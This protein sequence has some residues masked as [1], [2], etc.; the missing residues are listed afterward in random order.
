M[1]GLQLKIK[2][3][4]KMR[5][6]LIISALML[7]M[8]MASA[9]VF[10]FNSS[11]KRY[12]QNG[13]FGKKIDVFLD[14]NVRTTDT[15]V[16]NLKN[17]TYRPDTLL[18]VRCNV[19]MK[20]ES[21]SK[22]IIEVPSD[23]R[24]GDDNIF[25][26]EGNPGRYISVTVCN[27]SANVTRLKNVGSGRHL[28][29]FKYAKSVSFH[30]VNTT[31]NKSKCTNLDMR[32]CSNIDVHDCLFTNYNDEAIEG[33]CLWIEGTT[34]NVNIYN[35]TFRK[36]GNDEVIAVFNRNT[37]IDEK[38]LIEKRGIKIYG[39]KFYYG[40]ANEIERT[41][42]M[43]IS[44][45][46]SDDYIQYLGQKTAVH[47]KISDFEV[48]D[49][50]FYINDLVRRC[51]WLGFRNHTEVNRFKIT[52]NRFNYGEFAFAGKEYANDICITDSTLNKNEFEVSNNIFKSNDKICINGMHSCLMVNDA[53]VNFSGNQLIAKYGLT[54]LLV[55]HAGG[56][57]TMNSNV[58]SNLCYLG[59]VSQWNGVEYLKL[60]ATSNSF[61][62]NT[63]IYCNKLKKA[64][65]DF[66][67]NTFNSDKVEFFLQ[68]SAANGNLIFKDNIVNV[69]A[70]AGYGKLYVSYDEKP[71]YSFGNVQVEN[72]TFN[73][74]QSDL[75]NSF[76]AGTRAVVSGNKYEGAID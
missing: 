76:P 32:Q 23:L 56:A 35:N 14:K 64:D 17:G 3:T 38:P 44:C 6:I 66:R 31:L 68:N 27:L 43:L 21:I 34:H 7:T 57:V 61:S 51:F 50:D 30:G 48:S 29:K 20:G 54:L 15:V 59:S 33:G 42:D 74:K 16:I 69:N 18:I 75:F 37:P 67:N 19:I 12:F 72:N 4:D 10:T 13:W 55:G 47:Y 70:K 1:L 73:V 40:E 63:R 46:T 45:I 9:R 62:G 24:F 49:N 5:R 22:T 11:D 39:N 65:F 28:F 53:K 25:G 26:F 8:C 52:G 41:N 71:K 58:C 36:H 2:G 60:T